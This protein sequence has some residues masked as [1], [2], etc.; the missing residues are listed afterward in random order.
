ML[1]I[2]LGYW[3][4]SHLLKSPIHCPFPDSLCRLYQAFV[5][6]FTSSRKALEKILGLISNVSVNFVFRNNIFFLLQ[7]A[8]IKGYAR[9]EKLIFDK[10]RSLIC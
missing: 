9:D 1:K 6:A 4:Q 2:L 8:G 5:I 3:G 10:T 7:I